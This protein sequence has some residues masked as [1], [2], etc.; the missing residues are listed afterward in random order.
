MARYQ[1]KQAL[2]GAMDAFAGGGANP[3]S[4]EHD[5]DAGSAVAEER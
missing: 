2:K 4:G 3:G 5:G 1:M